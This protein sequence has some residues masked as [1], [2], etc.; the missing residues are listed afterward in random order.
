M[1]QS[2]ESVMNL[3][4]LQIAWRLGVKRGAH[5]WIGKF[6]MSFIEIQR[7][8]YQQSPKENVRQKSFCLEEKVMDLLLLPPCKSTY[9]HIL[10]SNY[11]ARN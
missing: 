7:Y 11:F 4:M 10:H 1:L 3:S 6:C 9:L 8:R 5:S 2:N